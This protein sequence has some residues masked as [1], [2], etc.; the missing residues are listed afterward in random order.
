ML[1]FKGKIL[2]ISSIFCPHRSCEHPPNLHFSQ[3]IP[4]LAASFT[5]KGYKGILSGFLG[6]PF[7]ISQCRGASLLPSLIHSWCVAK[8]DGMAQNVEITIRSPV[9]R[10]RGLGCGVPG[11]LS[12]NTA[13]YGAAKKQGKKKYVCLILTYRH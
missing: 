13:S 2:N 6:S 4:T 11:G 5:V 7:S 8:R 9:T 1:G 12:R 3:T 10:A